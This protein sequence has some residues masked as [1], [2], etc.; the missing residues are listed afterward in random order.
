MNFVEQ[1]VFNRKKLVRVLQPFYSISNRSLKML[2]VSNAGYLLRSLPRVSLN[3]RFITSTIFSL[4]FSKILKMNF[5]ESMLA[6]L[7][8]H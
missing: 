6:S 4:L 2:V 1:T 7:M 3:I 5:V 8:K